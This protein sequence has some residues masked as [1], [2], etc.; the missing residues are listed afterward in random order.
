MMVMSKLNFA[1]APAPLAMAVL[2]AG[3]GGAEVEGSGATEVTASEGIDS[4]ETDGD[5]SSADGS[6]TSTSS[7]NTTS[8]S[9]TTSTDTT[10]PDSGT[11]TDGVKFDTLD[12]VDAGDGGGQNCQGGD[13]CGEAEFSYIWIAN[14]GENT[15]TKLNT[16]TLEEEGRYWTRPDQGGSPS[17]TSVSVDGR[18]VAIANR[19]V[20][21]TKIWADL[22]DCE[23]KNNNGMI[24]TSTGKNDVRAFAADE[25]IAW[26][27]PFPDMSVQRPVAWTSGTYNEATCVWEN[28]KI[29]T[30]TGDSGSPGQCGETGV[31]VHRLN[32]DTGEVEDTI[33]IPHDEVKCT[34]G[35]SNW[36]LGPYGAAVDNE[37][38]MWF[39]VFGQSTVVRVN[40]SDLSYQIYSGG[41]YGLTVDSEG[42]PWTDAP[43][44][45]DPQGGQWTSAIGNLPGSGGTGVA[46]DLQGRIW[47]GTVGGVGWVDME[48]MVVGD[49]VPLPAQGNYRGVSVDVDG[50]IWAIPLG[51]TEAFRIDP[52]T[53]EIA[54]YMGLNAPYTYS[55]MSGGQLSNVTCNEPQG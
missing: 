29:W 20:G 30:T 41:S 18:A 16:R 45:L 17:R 52:D 11:E 15:V 7:T 44:R 49:T 31:Y 28:Q 55:D 26:H 21:I 36:G 23:D 8:T 43:R 46:Q 4:G 51:G 39:F 32:G 19:H 37:G 50:F 22:D 5:E 25:C 27:T 40:Y 12:P 6:T 10:D 38:N 13:I 33:H 3:C 53:Y 14:S 9:S 47:S 35:A 2:L 54:S 42:R 34:F 48:T 1:C 24:D